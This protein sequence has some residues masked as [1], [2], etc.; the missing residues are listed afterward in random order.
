MLDLDLMPAPIEVVTVI[1]L[2]NVPFE[3]DGLAFLTISR[4]LENFLS[5]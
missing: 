1:F 4:E 2:M 3:L 5:I